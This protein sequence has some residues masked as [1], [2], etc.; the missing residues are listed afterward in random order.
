MDRRARID[1]VGSDL[2]SPGHNERQHKARR[3]QK[4]VGV[5]LGTPRHFT[6]SSAY[7]V[8]HDYAI[9]RRLIGRTFGLGGNPMRWNFVASIAPEVVGSLIEFL[10]QH[11][12]R[13]QMKRLTCWLGR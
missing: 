5:L 3:R 13:E 1:E 2:G 8:G 7:R 10:L 9:I 11:A 6:R 4:T 12:T